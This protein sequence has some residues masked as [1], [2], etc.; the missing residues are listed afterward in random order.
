MKRKTLHLNWRLTHWVTMTSRSMRRVWHMCTKYYVTMY[1]I[2]IYHKISVIYSGIDSVED[3]RIIYW[4]LSVT[5]GGQ[6]QIAASHQKK[7]T[8]DCKSPRL[9]LASCCKASLSGFK[10]H[11]TRTL[12][13]SL[14][15][16]IPSSET[17]SLK[18]HSTPHTHQ[19]GW[20]KGFLFQKP[21]RPPSNLGRDLA[22]LGSPK[23]RQPS[24]WTSIRCQCLFRLGRKGSK[25]QRW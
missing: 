13:D 24:A 23:S 20:W 17:N 7:H 8:S 9:L 14:E 10:M 4:Q 2:I 25:T 6:P 15:H 3:Q 19:P 11:S 21:W 22:T 1:H 12:L 16:R 18:Q 5:I